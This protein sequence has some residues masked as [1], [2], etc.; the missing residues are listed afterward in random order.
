MSTVTVAAEPGAGRTRRSLDPGVVGG[1]GRLFALVVLMAIMSFVSPVF[2]GVRNLSTILTNAC[3]MIILG[4]GETIAIVTRGAD[5]SI[6][7]VLTITSVVAAIMVKAG[8]FYGWAILAALAFGLALGLLNGF[9]IAVV[10]LPSFVSTYGLLWALFGF[11]YLILNG[12]VIYGFDPAFRFVGN[13]Q[14]FGIVPMPIVVMLV[15]VAAGVFVMRKTTLGRKFYAVGANP[16]VA[17]MSGVNVSRTT[18]VAFGISG[19]LAAVAGIVQVARINACQADIGQPYL[20]P[21]L[22]TVAMGGTSF[23][24]GQGGVVGT[25]IGALIM[26]VVQNAM[27]LLGVPALWREA[28]I[29]ALIIVTV[30]TDISLRKRLTTVRTKGA[31]QV[32]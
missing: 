3:V 25:V 26:T 30:L 19:L 2:L 24:G 6:G 5:L 17:K 7:S 12:Y 15:V 18:I 4:V 14:L 22:A 27:N 32:A 16:D 23:A 29:G 31:G 1:L 21:T 20:L 11:A 10:G 28:I 13:G 8:V 9:M